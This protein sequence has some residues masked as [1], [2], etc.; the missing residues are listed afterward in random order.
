MPMNQSALVKT[1]LILITVVL[2]GTAFAVTTL[3]RTPGSWFYGPSP[4]WTA[5]STSNHNFFPL[6]PRMQFNTVSAARFSYQMTN[7]TGDCKLRAAIR[8][9]NDGIEW[10]TAEDVVSAYSDADNEVIYGTSYVDLTA[11]AGT[12]P[13]A[14]VQFGVE[15]V[16]RSTS[17]VAFCNATL[18]I[19]PKQW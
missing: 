7:D 12:T 14:W 10:D 2:G 19:E 17:N 3:Q 15:A 11:V 9:S 16:N 8:F 13:R 6:S 4:V 1:I 18:R 5:G